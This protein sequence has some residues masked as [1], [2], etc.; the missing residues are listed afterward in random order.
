MSDPSVSVVMATQDATSE[1]SKCLDSLA[2]QTLQQEVEVIIADCS[3]DGTERFIATKHPAVRLLHFPKPLNK[4]EL[5]KRALQEARGSIVVVTDHHCRFPSDWLE[6]LWRKHDTEFAVIGGAVEYAGSNSLV[7]WACYFADYGPF[8]LPAS[9]RITSFLAG[10]HVSYK[11]SLIQESLD[12]MP[13]GFWKVF[14]H[15]DLERKGIRCLFDPELVIACVQCETFWGFVRRYYRNGQYFAAMRCR[16]IS[17][18][19]RFLHLV[20]TPLLPP[21][22]LYRRLDAVRRKKKNRATLLFA[23][24]LLATFVVSWSVGELRGYLFG[25][26]S[27]FP[28][29]QGQDPP[30]GRSERELSCRCASGPR[31]RGT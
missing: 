25:P 29:W 22:L 16:R 30:A 15:W 24:P 7:S 27:R 13:D 9:R 20:T 10:N 12:S 14:F 6:K 11:R 21:L 17:P 8:M 3:T 5:L 4:P 31:S 18:A 23:V 28:S 1:V 26:G 19:A 2:S